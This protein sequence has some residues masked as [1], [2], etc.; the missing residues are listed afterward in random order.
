MS[1]PMPKPMP[2]QKPLPLPKMPEP[3]KNKQ[4]PE[5]KIEKLSDSFAPRF[6]RLFRE[7]SS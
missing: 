6:D 5:P 1:M 4:I 2:M 7:F 3:P